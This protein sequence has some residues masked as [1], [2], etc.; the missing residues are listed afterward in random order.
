MAR[1]MKCGCRMKVETFV[2]AVVD[3][4]KHGQTRKEL[5]LALGKKETTIYQRL[6]ELRRLG[7]KLP[8]LP[9]NSERLSVAERAKAALRTAQRMAK[10]R[11]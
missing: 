6:Y 11:A 7:V 1:N 10:S 3:A 8:L 5:A 9:A 2:H 4:H